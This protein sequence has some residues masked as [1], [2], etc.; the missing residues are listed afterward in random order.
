MSFGSSF[1]DI[2]N[3]SFSSVNVKLKQKHKNSILMGGIRVK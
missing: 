2:E 3:F 1:K